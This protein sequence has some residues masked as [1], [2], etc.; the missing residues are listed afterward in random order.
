M[1]TLKTTL[2]MGALFG[3]FIVL[4]GLFGGGSGMMIAFIIALVMN[5]SMYWYSDKIVLSMYRAQDLPAKSAPK[6]HEMVARLAQGAGIPKPRVVYVPMEVPNAFATGR[7]PEHGVVAV[8]KGLVNLLDEREIEGV[9]AHEIGH[10]RNRDTLIQCFAAA[11]GGAIMMMASF[12]RW[13]AIFGGFGRDDNNNLFELLAMAILAPI[14]ALLIQMGISRSRE[15][16]ADDTSARLTKNPEGLA[17]ALQKLGAYS[18]KYP[19]RQGNTATA[20]LFI[21]NP[22]KAGGI[23]SL[24]ST[25]P[26]IE[27][28][29]KRLR[30]MKKV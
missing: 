14:A 8:T 9:I 12:A 19:V 21:V 30:G 1:N 4:G 20:H 6:I 16:L 22:F 28:R 15:Y 5:F 25:H 3:V 13:G 17:D 10:I 24:F 11:M 29:V 2:L 18:K 7:D 27:D 23:A 26:P